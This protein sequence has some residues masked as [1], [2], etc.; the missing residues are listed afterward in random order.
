MFTTEHTEH[1]EN[2]RRL[3]PEMALRAN[4]NGRFTTEHAERQR[5]AGGAAA[6]SAGPATTVTTEHTEHAENGRR[7]MPEMAL[8]AH[9]NGRFTTE[10]TENILMQGEMPDSR[11]P[12]SG[13]TTKD[14]TAAETSQDKIV[15]P[16][17]YNRESS[18]VKRNLTAEHA[19]RQRCAGVT[20]AGTFA[21]TCL[22]GP[23]AVRS[24][25][26][27]RA[28]RVLWSNKCLSQCDEGD[29]G[30]RG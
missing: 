19:E 23:V 11:L 15:I 16:E 14:E 2:G 8:R 9:G 22:P 7:L 20:A 10:H 29:E 24:G 28:L 12:V 18:A 27:L 3:M 5:C 6:A 30:M 25:A 26:S 4:G 13:V 1:A 21:G 17:M